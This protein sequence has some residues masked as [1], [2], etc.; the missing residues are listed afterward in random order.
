MATI[1]LRAKAR[2]TKMDCGVAEM[3]GLKVGDVV[4]GKMREDWAFF[5]FKWNGGDATLII[6]DNAEIVEYE[7]LE[8]AVQD[9]NN[10]HHKDTNG[11][12]WFETLQQAKE[13]QKSLGG[14]IMYGAGYC[15]K[16]GDYI[17]SPFWCTTMKAA[18]Q[19]LHKTLNKYE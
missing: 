4:E 18:R 1:K 3:K 10:E 6:D 7:S 5:E 15:D 16:E 14:T 11:F 19:K 17:E 12:I 13:Y 9:N 2:V 8:Y